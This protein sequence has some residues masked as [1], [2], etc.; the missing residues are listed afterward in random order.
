MVNMTDTKCTKRDFL[1]KLGVG[2]GSLAVSSTVFK[3]IESLVNTADAETHDSASYAESA[4]HVPTMAEIDNLMAR[5]SV[6]EILRE[7]YG[8]RVK[9][10]TIEQIKRKPNSI[11]T[12]FK[13]LVYQEDKQPLDKRPSLVMFYVKSDKETDIQSREA[14]IFKYLSNTFSRDVNFFA[15]N[16]ADQ[17]DFKQRKLLDSNFGYEVQKEENITEVPS[18]GM[19]SIFDLV[20]YEEPKINDGL[21]KQVDILKGGPDDNKWIPEWITSLTGYWIKPNL[22]GKQSPENNGTLYI[23]KNTFDYQEIKGFKYQ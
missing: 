3:G 11:H 23:F 5:G 18:I 2:L 4:V 19:Y 9:K 12:N 20:E 7:E 15:Y 21:I 10:G 13:D 22:F 8:T 1:R 16:I 17:D 14:I 6:D